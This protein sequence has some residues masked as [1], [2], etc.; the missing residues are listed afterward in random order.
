M[1][2]NRYLAMN[3]CITLN[4]LNLFNLGLLLRVPNRSGILQ[5]QPHKG[6]ICSIFEVAHDFKLRLMNTSVCKALP[7]LIWKLSDNRA[8]HP[9]RK[10]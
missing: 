5:F 1:K 6:L 9:I 3:C 2:L 8:G 4:L 10:A 7:V